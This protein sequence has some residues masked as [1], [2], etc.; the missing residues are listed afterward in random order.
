MWSLND[1]FKI[2]SLLIKKISLSIH[3]IPYHSVIP[4]Q[5]L[6]EWE[7][8][9]WSGKGLEWNREKILCSFELKIAKKAKIS[10]TPVPSLYG[11]C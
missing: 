1:I 9:R 11:F 6:L 2:K 4:V 10:I 5:F 7:K 3:L 8:S